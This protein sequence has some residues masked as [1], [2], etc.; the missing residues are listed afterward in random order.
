MKA[1]IV[2]PYNLTDFE[3][4]RKAFSVPAHGTTGVHN[5]LCRVLV[6]TDTASTSRYDGI[7]LVDANR[8]P[9]RYRNFN[10][11]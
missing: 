7:V 4:C 3:E 10:K 2:H 1:M 8:S 11:R 6:Q 5:G 9:D